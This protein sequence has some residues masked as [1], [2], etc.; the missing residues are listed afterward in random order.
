MQT[1][2]FNKDDSD[3]EQLVYKSYLVSDNTVGKNDFF[4]QQLWN[5]LKCSSIEFNQIKNLEYKKNSL[6][7]FFTKYDKCKNGDFKSDKKRL[8][9][10]FSIYLLDLVSTTLLY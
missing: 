7:N 9:N 8:R 1:F 5:N 6:I 2:F 3:I 10:F 4:K